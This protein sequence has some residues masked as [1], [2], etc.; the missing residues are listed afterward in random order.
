MA[1]DKL[2]NKTD[3]IK[4]NHFGNGRAAK[5]TYIF[6][7]PS[8]R[9]FSV[10]I[11]QR[12]V[13]YSYIFTISNT[14]DLCVRRPAQLSLV[15]RPLYLNLQQAAASSTVAIRKVDSRRGTMF[16]MSSRPI[17]TTTSLPLSLSVARK[18]G[19]FWGLGSRRRM[20]VR[21]AFAFA[22][23]VRGSTHF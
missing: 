7:S 5:A 14:T 23:T 13:L 16:K 11:V 9:L 15:F 6:C 1:H 20:Y 22:A 21:N 12:F 18:R 4:W 3:K 17:K 19:A 10:Q 2:N 8:T